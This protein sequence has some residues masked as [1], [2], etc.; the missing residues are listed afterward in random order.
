MNV[1]QLIIDSVYKYTKIKF[2]PMTVRPKA[3][4][5]LVNKSDAAPLIEARHIL[6]QLIEKKLAG[7]PCNE[8]D[9][10]HKIIE[11]IEQAP[12]T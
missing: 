2:L 11:L 10:L 3:M 5:A 7:T 8:K 4:E 6:D 12:V 1:R 9:D